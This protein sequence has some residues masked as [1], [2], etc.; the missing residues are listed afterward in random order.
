MLKIQ[1]HHKRTPY[2]SNAFPVEAYRWNCNDQGLYY[3]GQ[4]LAGGSKQAANGYWH[5]YNSPINPFV[6]AGWRGTCSFPQITTGGLDDSWTHGH[7][8][9]GVYHDLLDFLPSRSSEEWKSKVLYRV[10]NNVIT[11]Q[12]AGMLI[13]G[14]WETTDSIPLLIQAAGIDSLEPQYSCDVGKSLSDEIKSSSNPD[15]QK[16]L[17]LS[18]DLFAALD[19]ISGVPKDDSG[20]HVSF[21][22]YFD[23]LSAR[24]CHAKPLPCKLADAEG[25]NQNNSTTT[26]DCVD[27]VLADAVY[28]MGQWE[29]SQI[30]R[31]ANASLSASVTSYGV[32]I[33]ELSAHLRDVMTG[34][35]GTPMYMHNVAH[36][37]STSRVLSI[38][39][40]D[41]MVS[42]F[43]PLSKP[44]T[45][46][47]V[48]L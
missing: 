7:D 19:A 44:R 21:D 15:W 48:D 34:R 42:H 14:M 31:D 45:S 11:S 28:R 2:A 47:L 4:P 35:E 10:T 8:L 32:W 22:H 24:Q 33:A 40:V 36:D 41:S 30:Y 13:N 39:Q 38:L 3:Y 5:G 17:D 20:F 29:Y 23:N 12:V 18:A 43:P 46:L 6:A 25:H 26:D 1:R 9:Y 16:H 27:Q 37:G